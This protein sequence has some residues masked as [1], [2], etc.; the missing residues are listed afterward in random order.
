MVLLLLPHLPDWS[1]S[2]VGAGFCVM[3]RFVTFF[4]GFSVAGGYSTRG[5]LTVVG[6]ES[7]T[8][9][10][11]V[12]GKTSSIES[13]LA[14]VKRGDHFTLQRSG[15]DGTRG[16]IL[17]MDF[18]FAVPFRKSVP[19]TS[20]LIKGHV[21]TLGFE[22]D[23]TIDVSDSGF[24]FSLASARLFGLYDA[25]LTC[26]SGYGDF[27]SAAFEVKG[28]LLANFFTALNG[29]IRGVLKQA[30]DLAMSNIAAA[31][32]AVVSS[33]QNVDRL[34]SS[35]HS[36]EDQESTR[37]FGLADVQ[38]ECSA[39]T[40]KRAAITSAKSTADSVRQVLLDSIS[41]FSSV[42]D[43][44]DPNGFI[45]LSTTDYNLAL[46]WITKANKVRNHCC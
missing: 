20:A 17:T 46:T 38:R 19:E 45:P 36:L 32:Q 43:I 27:P 31:E 11:H 37:S 18:K 35:L 33:Q 21:K 2:V 5:L 44:P 7:P 14:P 15:S 40:A 22:R 12:P 28:E 23:I 4:F 9:I 16:A 29:E 30:A 8:T 41:G 39:A 3:F 34:Q 25:T 24:K 6:M 1:A 13:H 26:E 42:N 10:V